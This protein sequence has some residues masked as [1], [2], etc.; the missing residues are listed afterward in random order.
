MYHYQLWFIPGL[1]HTVTLLGCL[2]AAYY[3]CVN[4]LLDG[5]KDP[6]SLGLRFA[7]SM[8]RID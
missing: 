7:R 2:C 6:S 3:L 5:F 1:T 4:M 8:L